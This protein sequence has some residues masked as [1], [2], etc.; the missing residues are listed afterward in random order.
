MFGIER[1][2]VNVGAEKN[3]PAIL[4]YYYITQVYFELENF[5]F[6]FIHAEDY[7]AS[8]KWQKNI[9]MYFNYCTIIKCKCGEVI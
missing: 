1:K 5:S 8:E 3:H 7:A 4:L 2:T 9:Y 6:T